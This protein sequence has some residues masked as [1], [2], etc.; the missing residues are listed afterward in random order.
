MTSAAAAHS[1]ICIFPISDKRREPLCQ[2]H[3]P[4]RLMSKARRAKAPQALLDRPKRLHMPANYA[5]IDWG[6]N[7]GAMMPR[8]L[9]QELRPVSPFIVPAVLACFH[10][11]PADLHRSPRVSRELE[12]VKSGAMSAWRSTI[13]D[14]VVGLAGISDG[15]LSRLAILL[16]LTYNAN[17]L[18]RIGITTQGRGDGQDG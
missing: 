8:W 5:S 11:I 15:L 1:A 14:A 12:E 4:E 16:T 7:E 3:R 9:R 18:H 2:P 6:G 10:L 17:A 13:S